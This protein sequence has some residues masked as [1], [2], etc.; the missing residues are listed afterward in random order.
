MYMQGFKCKINNATSTIPIAEAK[1]PV[2]CREDPSTCVKGAKQMIAF[3]RMCY[4][5]IS[6]NIALILVPNAELEGNNMNVTSMGPNG[7]WDTPM[8]NEQCG[9]SSGE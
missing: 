4:F 2:F 3:Y 1:A 8:Y 5:E 9:W 7:W 6:E